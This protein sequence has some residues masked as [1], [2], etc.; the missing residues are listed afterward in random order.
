[1]GLILNLEALRSYV[2]GEGWGGGL[3][4]GKGG[5]SERCLKWGGGG[6]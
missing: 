1:M 2:Y 3:V 6:H 5:S 4:D